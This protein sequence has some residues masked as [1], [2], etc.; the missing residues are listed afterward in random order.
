M[1]SNTFLILTAGAAALGVWGIVQFVLG[2]MKPEKRA[3]ARR[4][5]GESSTLPPINTLSVTMQ[6]KDA[7]IPEALAGIKY[8]QNLNRKL[9]QAYPDAKFTK[10]LVYMVALGVVGGSILG[11]AMESV[12]AGLA[13]FVAGAYLPVMYI[14]GRRA[15]RQKRLTLQLP[16]ALEFLTRVLRAG[17]SLST[18]L[19]MMGDE[20]PDPLA[21]EFRRAY[22]Q[23]SLGQ[24]LED[25]LREMAKRI[26]SSDFAFFVTAVL[27][28]RQTGGDLSEVLQN[29]SGMVRQRI[30]L[31]SHVKAITAE[32]RLT[33]YVLVGFPCVLFGISYALNPDY[34]GIL[35]RN[36]TG[37]LMLAA[38]VG[39]QF[40]GL[41]VIR[42]IV[43]VEV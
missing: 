27:I 9:V 35:I 4:L 42:K 21:A 26:E 1:D 12:L 17:H 19:Q 24:T 36:D 18:G 43:T 16:E 25:A 41:M 28:Q 7:N 38:A 30:R 32:G 39:L 40:I 8:F 31:Q 11:L 37:R 6:A 15:K 34:A 20:L 33:S 14:N 22:A 13:G 3:L 29:I 23:H 5:S 2:A 10:M